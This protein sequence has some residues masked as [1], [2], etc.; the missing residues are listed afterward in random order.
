LTKK[1]E[2]AFRDVE[3]GVELEV[4]DSVSWLE[5]IA[6]HYKDFGAILEIVTDRSQEGSQFCKG[7][8]GIGGILRYRVDFA[9]L[10]ANEEE[11]EGEEQELDFI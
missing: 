3:T 7:F 1:K 10:N 8:G 9:L 11:H 2:N 6:N 4:V 5:W